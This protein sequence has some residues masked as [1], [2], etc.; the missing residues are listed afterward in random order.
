MHMPGDSGAAVVE[1]DLGAR[2][3]LQA[4]ADGSSLL[5]PYDELWFVV[6]GIGYCRTYPVGAGGI[7]RTRESASRRPNSL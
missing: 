5:G 1:K 7:T 4:G 3:R 6:L 2:R